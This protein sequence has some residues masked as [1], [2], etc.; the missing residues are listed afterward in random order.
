MVAWMTNVYIVHLAK[1]FSKDWKRD[2]GLH[3]Q[4]K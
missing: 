3:L 2:N 4:R 1:R